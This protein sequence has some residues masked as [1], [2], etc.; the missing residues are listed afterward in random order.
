[1]VIDQTWNAIHRNNL[2]PARG[3]K[4]ISSS[5]PTHI[6]EATHAP[7]GDGNTFFLSVVSM[8][9]RNNSHP[10][11]GRKLKGRRADINAVETTHTPQGDG[12]ISALLSY[13]AE[14]SETTYTPQG[15]GSFSPMNF[16]QCVQRNNLHPE[17]GRTLTEGRDAFETENPG[18]YLRLPAARRG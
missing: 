1:M 7:Q 16:F 14:Y 17:R 12:N 4:L 3:R 2:H 8:L 9:V 15:D 13:L 6:R 10:A 18:A 11:R 5:L